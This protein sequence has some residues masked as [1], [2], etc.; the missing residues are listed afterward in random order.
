[1]IERVGGLKLSKGL[2]IGAAVFLL[3][4]IAVEFYADRQAYR[5][6]S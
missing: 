4:V 3:A 2:V 6:E 1:M 5:I